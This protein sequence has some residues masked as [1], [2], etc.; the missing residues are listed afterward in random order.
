MN[1]KQFL[2]PALKVVIWAC[3]AVV[4]FSALYVSSALFFPFITSKTFAFQ[5]AVEVMF[6]AF[7]L[8]CLV[9]DKYH[10]RLN[11]TVLLLLLYLIIL[12]IASAFS[13]NDLYHSFWSNNERCDGILLLI[14]LFLFCAVL[15]GFFR[16]VKEWLYL[17]DLFLLASFAVALVA[18]DQYLA[19]TFV[20]SWKD[21][22]LP[23]SN[24][25][26]LAGTIGNSGYVG[27]YMVFGIF[28]ALFMALKR[29]QWWAKSLY[30]LAIILEL[31]IA[32]QTFTRGAYLALGL[33]GFITLVYLGY[34]YYN[35]LRLKIATTGLVL[36]VSLFIVVIFGCG[37][38]KILTPGF[39]FSW[40][41]GF[42]KTAVCN[43]FA[44]ANPVLKRI[45]SISLTDVTSNN[46]IVAWTIGLK[47]IAARPILG[48]GQ[49]NFY[50]VFDK[51][52]TTKSS[53]QWFDRCH[54]MFCDRAVT[55]GIPGLLSY[56]AVLLLPFFFLWKYYFKE[57]GNNKEQGD[58]DRDYK[59]Y[60]TP[61]IFS[62]LIIAY[63]IQ[64]FFI[65]EALAIY[66]PLIIVLSFVGQYSRSWNFD[67]LENHNFKVALAV[68]VG[69]LFLPALWFFSLKP[70]YANADFIK[71][72]TR[73]WPTLQDKI[74]S[75]EEVI[76][77][78]TLGNQEYRKHYFDFYGNELM[79]YLSQAAN[80]TSDKDRQMAN[81]SDLMENQFLNQLK[82]NPHSVTN[83]LLLE[84]FYNISYVFNV[85]RLQKAIGI[86]DQMIALSPGRPQIYY[87][88]GSANYYL[89]CFLLTEKNNPV[90]AK[91]QYQQALT[92]FWQG[93]KINNQ[94]GNGFDQFSDF[95]L[96]IKNNAQIADTFAQALAT[97]PL[98][99]IAPLE[100][101]K[102]LAEWSKT[103]D[104]QAIMA[105]RE[106][107]LK[108]MAVWLIASRAGNPELKQYLET[109]K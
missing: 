59:K 79:S 13:G 94:V 2:A 87:E 65:F 15:S 40:E 12:T 34:F 19:L 69:I 96:S 26:R 8:L 10:I 74:D 62:I 37:S 51:Y 100:L 85:N 103:P 4:L 44:Y 6:L 20:G 67:F 68:I 57:Y 84:R 43:N 56:L 91:K 82:E 66:I 64:N 25:A 46:R 23:S 81:W 41:Q 31:F 38:G 97:G 95:V 72:L 109:I 86:A 54:N 36:I 27:G 47:G 33:G 83:W 101:I 102:Q 50:Q 18:L 53:E 24:G 32:V 60:L 5:I 71:A 77:R 49:E 45:N 58:A 30:V 63:L 78:G 29:S 39:G 11:V 35:K 3:L 17:F 42:H 9:D 89:G 106:E 22:F 75:F 107:K 99:D 104:D 98:D 16:S 108:T 28:I 93:A 90:E 73:P 52:Y 21:H 7:L 1:L 55:G 105:Q 48:Y 61:V 92:R 70:F 88:A 80:R 76:G 14:H